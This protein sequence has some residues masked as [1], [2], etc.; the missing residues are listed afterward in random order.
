MTQPDETTGYSVGDH[1]AAIDLHGG[2]DVLDYVI[3]NSGKI[4]RKVSRRYA[5][6]GSFPVA[7]DAVRVHG[8][9]PVRANMV[10]PLEY[11]RHDPDRLARVVMKIIKGARVA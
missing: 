9:T 7:I 3:V 5:T 11:A 10:S 2:K 8:A 6:R 4:P 1:L